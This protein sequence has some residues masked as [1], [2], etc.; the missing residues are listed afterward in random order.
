MWRFGIWWDLISG[1]SALLHEWIYRGTSKNIDNEFIGHEDKKIILST[2]KYCVYL[3]DLVCH[4][5]SLGQVV[6]FLLIFSLYNQL[7]SAGEHRVF[8]LLLNCDTNASCT[9]LLGDE[10]KRFIQRS[11]QRHLKAA[12]DAT[13]HN[14]HCLRVCECDIHYE[15][16]LTYSS[17]TSP[18]VKI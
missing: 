5:W 12:C 8:V 4:R 15:F 9:E 1:W 14:F 18:G 17:N 2:L 13:I 10:T 16:L 6:R 3:S 7:L 11:I